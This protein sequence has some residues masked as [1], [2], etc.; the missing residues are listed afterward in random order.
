MPRGGMS[1]NPFGG[2]GHKEAKAGQV[3]TVCGKYKP[4]R[5]D[6]LD[7]V[8]W[9]AS[10]ECINGGEVPG[11]QLL[12][13]VEIQTIVNDW[14]FFGLAEKNGCTVEKFWEA[15]EYLW[16]VRSTSPET[17]QNAR[18]LR[19]TYFDESIGKRRTEHIQLSNEQL[20][21][22]CFDT[23]YDMAG[24]SNS[25]PMEVFLENL[26]KRR[27]L[28]L[29]ENKEQVTK[30]VALKQEQGMRRA[31]ALG[32]QMPFK[33]ID[34]IEVL[35][36]PGDGQLLAELVFYEP[37]LR[38]PVS[39]L[40]KPDKPNTMTSLKIRLRARKRPPRGFGAGSL[41]AQGEPCAENVA[42]LTADHSGGSD[43]GLLY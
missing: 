27:A 34:P 38:K 22:M 12:W 28:L 11:E 3:C 37:R 29:K 42:P 13:L 18:I 19:V 14:L 39:Q 7:I 40:E 33:F 17:W 6:R 15:N 26:R 30:F 9:V 43:V 24:L 16:R 2:C 8:S 5:L 21:A 35:A 10:E 31:V 23:H 4:Q 41:F 32:R 36:N 20:K 25:M 1:K